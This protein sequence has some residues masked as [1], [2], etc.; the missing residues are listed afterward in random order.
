MLPYLVVIHSFLFLSTLFDVLGSTNKSIRF[1]TDR[2]GVIEV[3]IRIRSPSALQS[4]RSRSLAIALAHARA[5][6]A[7]DHAVLR[8]GWLTCSI[9]AGSEEASSPKYTAAPPPRRPGRKFQ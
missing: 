2:L 1:Y 3:S 6:Q 4:E 9:I 7:S 8:A 5:P